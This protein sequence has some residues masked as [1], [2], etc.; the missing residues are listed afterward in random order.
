MTA[1]MGRA[2]HH[3]EGGHA[4]VR[5]A[6]HRGDD[7]NPLWQAWRMS[8]DLFARAREALDNDDP[9][10]ALRA[11]RSGA[12]YPSDFETA[13]WTQ[14][15]ELLAQI[16]Q[17]LGDD[18]GLGAA[19]EAAALTPTDGQVLYDAGYHLIEVGL[20][21]LAAGVLGFALELRPGDRAIVTELCCALEDDMRFPDARAALEA[22]PELWQEANMARYLLA[23]HRLMTADVEGARELLDALLKGDEELADT[24]RQVQ[25]M[26]TRADAVA[27]VTSLS[28]SDLRGWHVVVNGTVLLHESPHGR[29]AGMNGRY[30]WVQDQEP[31]CRAAIELA[32]TALDELGMEMPRVF[33]LPDRDSQILGAAAARVWGLPAEPWPGEGAGIIVAYDLAAVDEE[34]WREVAEHRPGQ[35]LWAHASQWTSRHPFGADLVTFLYQE[36][37]SPWAERLIIDPET[38]ATSQAPAD[39]A[40]VE[41]VAARIAALEPDTSDQD[42][43]ALGRLIRAATGA[44]GRFAPLRDG[45]RRRRQW[46]GSPVHSGR[47]V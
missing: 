47:F 11:L 3:I 27:D 32:G 12:R 5:G 20:P 15:F 6:E 30:A 13:A 24:A 23:F 41:A 28:P 1:F 31:L 36:N 16:G 42:T 2:L 35:L 26:V 18:S 37:T 43:E 44:R 14:L 46:C 17:K 10:G 22:F 29:D 34:T 39:A 25:D 7:R 21:D 9:H 19:L 45:G 33:L 8:D 4:N 38:K 40:P